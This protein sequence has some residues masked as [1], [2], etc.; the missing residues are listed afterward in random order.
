MQ[1]WI[2]QV[3]Y[4]QIQMNEYR[5]IYGYILFK[6]TSSME[7]QMPY[8]QEVGGQIYPCPIYINQ[9]IKMTKKIT[10]MIK[11]ITNGHKLVIQMT[12]Y[13][14]NGWKSFTQMTK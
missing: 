13:I 8:K 3:S 6:G 11:Y 9:W 14:T 5:F 4:V 7:E 10:T 2:L 1:S 12:K